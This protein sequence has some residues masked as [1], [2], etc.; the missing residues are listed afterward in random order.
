M[1]NK[2]HTYYKNKIKEQGRSQKWV[3]EQLGLSREAFC[4]R[5]NGHTILKENEK[6]ELDKILGL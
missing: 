3:A 6:E 1:A 2:D 4:Y 5:M